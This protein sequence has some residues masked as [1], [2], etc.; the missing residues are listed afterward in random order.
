MHSQLSYTAAKLEIVDRRRRAERELY[1]DR[2]EKA[3]RGPRRS[4]I[5]RLTA[6]CRRTPASAVE[7]AATG[8]DAA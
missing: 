1:R 3:A 4:P 2:P 6:L 8:S 5:V 7:V